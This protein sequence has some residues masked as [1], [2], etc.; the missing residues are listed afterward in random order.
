MN[1]NKT[2]IKFKK[3]KTV[4]N[5][6]IKVEEKLSE[7]N[8]ITDNSKN[9]N[10]NINYVEPIYGTEEINYD[11]IR[12]E[13]DIASALEMDFIAKALADHKSKVAP[14]SHPDFDGKHCIDCGVDIP[15]I[16]LNMGKI[17]CV[18][19]QSELELRNKLKGKK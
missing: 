9:E 16:R 3:L 5:Q 2:T 17:R 7:K 11:D 13:A 6:E 4:K 14:E 10:K 15:L 12:D 1:N 19:C 8:K 18:D